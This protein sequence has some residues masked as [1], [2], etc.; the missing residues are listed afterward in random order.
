MPRFMLMLTVVGALMLVAP[1]PAAAQD[2]DCGD[3]D[4][5]AEAQDFYE[6]AGPGDPHGRDADDD[7]RACDSNPCPCRGPAVEEV[8][9]EAANRVSRSGR[10]RSAPRLFG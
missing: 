2:R 9:E 1:A 3:F 7:G 5:Q 4:S 10:K 6:N 8:G